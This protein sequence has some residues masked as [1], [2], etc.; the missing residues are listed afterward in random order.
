MAVCR[1]HAF[2]P[3]RGVKPMHYADC[4][5]CRSLWDRH[6]RRRR[7]VRNERQVARR[8]GAHRNP[9]SGAL[10]PGNRGDVTREGLGRLFS[11][12]EV[13]QRAAW[14]IPAW[15]AECRAKAP[16]TGP[17]LLVV[18]RPGEGKRLAILDYDDL[19]SMLGDYLNSLAV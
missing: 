3:K 18:S 13:R 6:E 10:T 17:W 11:L 16:V 12:I 5:L 7:W 14:A 4:G 15:V 19:A 2:S 9:G 1:L 8:A